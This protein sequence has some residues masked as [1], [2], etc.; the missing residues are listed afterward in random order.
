MLVAEISK[1]LKM[2]EMC[3]CANVQI[4]RCE[5]TRSYHLHNCIF[6]YLHIESCGHCYKNYP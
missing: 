2:V 4:C 3:R 5:S 6:T 1:L